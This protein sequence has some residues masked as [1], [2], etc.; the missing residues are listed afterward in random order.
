MEEIEQRFAHREQVAFHAFYSCYG[1]ITHTIPT[2]VETVDKN[3]L[4]RPKEQ[5]VAFFSVQGFDGALSPVTRAILPA[6]VT[7]LNRNVAETG[8][9]HSH[10]RQL[11]AFKRIGTLKAFNNSFFKSPELADSPDYLPSRLPLGARS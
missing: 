5:T 3:W 6:G 11:Q 8:G 7:E 10:A 9:T 4:L 2:E 1:H